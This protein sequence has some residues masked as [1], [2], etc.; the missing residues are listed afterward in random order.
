M[1]VGKLRNYLLI[2]NLAVAL[3]Y[4]HLHIAHLVGVCSRIDAADLFAADVLN[5]V[6]T[7]HMVV[8]KEN[9]VESRHLLSHLPRC[10]LLAVGHHH[11]LVLARMEQS[12]KNIGLLFFLDTIYQIF[13]RLK[14]IDRL[15]TTPK[16]MRKPVGKHRRR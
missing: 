5:P 16:A 3:R 11:S 15:Q 6:E 14:H 4:N 2:N 8:P 13:G 9:N 10:V 1:N 7:A 12:N